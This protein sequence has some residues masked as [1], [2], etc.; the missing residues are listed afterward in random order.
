[1]R[2]IVYSRWDG[3]QAEFS[4]DAHRALN[5]L[6]DLRMEGLDVR[7]ALEWMRR[8]GFEY[9]PIGRESVR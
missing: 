8:H 5:A 1:M 3:S 4:L 9:Y 6:S 2:S 7:Q